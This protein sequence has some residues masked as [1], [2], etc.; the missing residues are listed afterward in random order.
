M[1]PELLAAII[2]GG[3]AVLAALILAASHLMIDLRRR[4]A[5]QPARPA[6]TQSQG[7]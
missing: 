5:Q 4:R 2:T 7:Q 6:A 1:N 3:C